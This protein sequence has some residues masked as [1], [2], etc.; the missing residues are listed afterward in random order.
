MCLVSTYYLFL[1]AGALT[2]RAPAT[3]C[4]RCPRTCRA[5]LQL[6]RAAAPRSPPTPRTRPS[7]PPPAWPR[8]RCGARPW[9]P[10]GSAGPGP[11]SATRSWQTGETLT[12]Y[13]LG[14]KQ[15]R[16]EWNVSFG[17]VTKASGQTEYANGVNVW[18]LSIE[19]NGVGVELASNVIVILMCRQV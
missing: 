19:D 13:T 9:P 11:S 4:P 17:V 15:V 18:I 6:C 7:P 3:R 16:A 1:C 2:T 10:A 12:Q 14:G 8:P 5:G